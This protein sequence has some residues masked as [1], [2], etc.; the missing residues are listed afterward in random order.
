MLSEGGVFAQDIEA[1]Y[2]TH[3]LETPDDWWSMIMG[4]GYRGTVEQLS[5]K[6]RGHVREV[7]LSY[8][9]RE[10]VKHVETNVIYAVADKGK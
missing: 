3:E 4:S 7:N 1:E 2:G 10:G 5:A 6:D 9:R 8:I